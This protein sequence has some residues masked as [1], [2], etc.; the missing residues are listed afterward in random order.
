[1]SARTKRR[2]AIT[3]ISDHSGWAELVTVDVEADKPVVVDRRRVKLIADSLP[4]NPYHHEGLQ[5]PIVATD[6]LV[7]RVRASVVEHARGALA[8]LQAEFRV[9]GV[10]LQQSPFASL[11]DA[12][13]DVLGSYPLTCAADGMMYRETLAICAAELGMHVDRYPRKS[14]QAAAAAEALDVPP[15]TIA[16]LLSAFGRVIGP[17]WRKEHKRAAAS[18]VRVLGERHAIRL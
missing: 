18:A 17:P 14:D 10:A 8:Q 16:S 11:P 4:R 15:R 1:M 7:R 3:G 6:R 5:L 12:A 13:H 9:V 2:Q